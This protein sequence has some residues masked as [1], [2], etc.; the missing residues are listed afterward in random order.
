MGGLCFLCVGC[1]ILVDGAI[2][3]LVVSGSVEVFEV[4]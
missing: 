4:D 2:M 3:R 1:G